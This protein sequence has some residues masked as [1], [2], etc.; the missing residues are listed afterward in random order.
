MGP[1]ALA[2]DFSFVADAGQSVLGDWIDLGAR[3]QI[4]N[5]E[6]HVH[7]QT[8][9]PMGGPGSLDVGL[10]SSYDEVEDNLVAPV[11]PLMMTGSRSQAITSNL[12]DKVRLSL[13]NNSASLLMGIVSVWLQLKAD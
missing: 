4:Q 11:M 10:R 13:T 7:C 12:A 6:L 9:W 8:L 5:A 1:I 3:S 2:R